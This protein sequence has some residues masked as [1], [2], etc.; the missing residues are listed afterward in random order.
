MKETRENTMIEKEREF[1]FL[2][3]NHEFMVFIRTNLMIEKKRE[4]FFVCD[5]KCGVL[6]IMKL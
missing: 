5:L 3:T 2:R 6:F 1:F 4:F